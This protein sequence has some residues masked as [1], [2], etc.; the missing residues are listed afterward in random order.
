MPQILYNHH[1]SGPAGTV[2]WSSPQRDPYNFNLDPLV[3][4][5]VQ[6]LGTHM[7]QRLAAEGKAGATMA[8][9]GP[10]D[11][12]WNGGIRN[13]ANFHNIIAILTETIG[14]PTPMRIPFVPARQIPGRDQPFPIA[15]QEWRFRQSVEYS[16]SFNRA[17]IDYAA[18][19]REHLLYNIYRMGRRAIERGSEDYW[20][21]SP[22]RIN[23]VA[24]QPGGGGGAAAA[25]DAW[26]ALR[27][28][29]LR[30]PRG[31]IIPSDQP[32]F[33]TAVKF[34]NALREVNVEVH[35]AVKDFLV[36]GRKYPAG[37][38]VV[39]TAQAFRPH[40]L[41]MFE[42]QDHPNV[43]PYPGASPT[44]P[45]DTAGWTLAFQMGVQ[46]DRILEPFTGPFERVADWNVPP[47][48]GR[49]NTARGNRSLTLSRQVNDASRIVNR[50]LAAGEPVTMTP[51]VFYFASGGEST[52]RLQAWS[53][54]LGVTIQSVPVASRATRLR[55][56]R[57]GLWDQYGG[58][59]PSG[60]T[61]WILEQ[62]EFPFTRVFAQELDA[63]NLNKKFDVLVF[64]TG[65]IP[66]TGEPGGGQGGGGA[67][68]EAHEVPEE[69]RAQLGRIT[70]EQTIPRLRQFVE[71]GGTVVAIGSSA[72]NLAAHLQLPVE[73]H[74]VEV[75]K[76]LPRSQ[77]FVPGSVLQ[78]RVDTTHPIAAG[79]SERTDFFFNN[80]PVFRVRPDAL[81][82]SVRPIAA[83]DSPTP[84]RSGWAWGQHQLA[85]GVA[86][87]EVTLGK[88]R[89][90]LFGPEILHR[91]QPH[92]TFKLLFNSVWES[93][94][95][96]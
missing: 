51:E 75:G 40:V 49:V 47:P 7:H 79:L 2:V 25:G 16:L 77:Y 21:P 17:V 96:R 62:F 65:A 88:G 93:V 57:I 33:L 83:F 20:T 81:G 23:S 11:G 95:G 15:P 34:I 31:F 46:F 69:Y 71:A 28:P 78:A 85:G 52:K 84:L 41:D 6:A 80:S 22:T 76:P 90:L 58:S 61:R 94:A 3:I 67:G 26:A 63:G 43:I 24:E 9:A 38:F 91:A 37:S 68:L 56:P 72:S 30:D 55:A 13:T 66:G 73:N 45:Y 89:V 50:M 14:S 82:T 60:W 35:R 8:A 53:K 12:W 59:M 48:P 19:N 18:R 29:E 5:G 70:A 44:P 36:N 87:A 92:G 74:L 64:V 54:E 27:L 32:D 1:Q 10:Y 4:L 86:A 39:L 42:P